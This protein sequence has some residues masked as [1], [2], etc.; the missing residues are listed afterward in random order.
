[1]YC[2]EAFP[3]EELTIDHVEPLRIGG[4]QSEGNLVTCCSVCNTEKGGEPAW[5]YLARHPGK[6]ETFLALATGV[7]P[8]LRRAIVEAAAKQR[9]SG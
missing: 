8:R 1:M 4:D 5:R 2:G 9:Q 7:W 3:A 6:R